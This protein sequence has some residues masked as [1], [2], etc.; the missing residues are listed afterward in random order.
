MAATTTAAETLAHLHREASDPAA[1]YVGAALVSTPAP[2]VRC[3][4]AAP[5]LAPAPALL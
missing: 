4:L 2:Q 3:A 1:P 5:L